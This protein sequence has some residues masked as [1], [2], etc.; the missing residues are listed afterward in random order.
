[1]RG[2]GVGNKPVQEAYGMTTINTDQMEDV[3]GI[4][5]GFG[6]G[7]TIV[8][9]DGAAGSW[10]VLRLEPEFDEDIPLGLTALG[11]HS[12]AL[13]GRA[14]DDV[15]LHTFFTDETLERCVATVKQAAEEAGR[16]PASVR[17]WSC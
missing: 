1:M 12:L 15:I 10:P 8:G 3:D 5:R 11:E 2:T 9:H 6:K 17:V 16:E 14:F 7:E 13:G 4:Q